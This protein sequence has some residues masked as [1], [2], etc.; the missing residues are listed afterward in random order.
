MASNPGSEPTF[1]RRGP[2]MK[3][4][5]HLF[6]ALISFENLLAAYYKARKGKR[7]QSNVGRFDLHLERNLVRLQEQLV[8]KTYRPGSY[9]SFYVHDPKRRLVSAAPFVDRVVHH[10]LCRVIEPIYE[11]RFISD[12]YAC[13]RGKGTHRAVQRFCTFMARN[14]YVLK[15]DIAQYFPSV[16]HA[17]LLGVLARKIAD[18]DVLW[19]I[20]TI[21]DSGRGILDREYTMQWFPDDNLFAACRP[22]GLPIGNLTSQFFANVYLHELDMFVKQTLRWKPYL[23]YCDDFVLFGN[24]KRELQQAKDAI[25]RFLEDLRLCLHPKKTGVFPVR[26]GTPF[27]GYRI[28]PTHIRINKENVRRFV[29]RMR[30]LQ[31]NYNQGRIALRD[32]Q[33]SVQAW[34]AHASHADSYRLREAIL[35][36]LVFRKPSTH[37][38]SSNHEPARF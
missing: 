5:K 31:S 27:L 8:T 30:R 16:D 18:P 7:L 36:P 35:E 2:H 15:A 29:R 25:S 38:P 1:G 9:H 21:L 28:Y 34:V 24:D 20:E 26:V 33:A 3:T 6:P 32:I 14:T 10:A 12:S 13:R 23:R 4:V 22:R 11:V 19:L 17:I 37:E